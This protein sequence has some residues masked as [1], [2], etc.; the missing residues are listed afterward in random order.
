LLKGITRLDTPPRHKVPVS[1]RLLE[2]CFLSLRLD[3]PFAQALCGGVVCVA[4][5]FLLR[6][7]EIVSIR[8]N[9]PR[10]EPMT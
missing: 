7:S 3:D 6:R 8:G 4:F 5:F 1:I 10:L 9:S 2:T